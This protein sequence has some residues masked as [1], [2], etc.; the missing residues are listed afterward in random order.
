MVE[1]YNM[2]ISEISGYHIGELVEEG[3]YGRTYKVLKQ[4]TQV[5]FY[6]YSIFII[7]DLCIFMI[8]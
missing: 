3:Q 4:L 2:N 1:G 8:I 5:T 7:R 6:I